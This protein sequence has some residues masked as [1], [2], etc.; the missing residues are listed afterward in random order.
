MS[1]QFLRG[2]TAQVEAYTG[3]AGEIVIN[4]ETNDIYIHDGTTQGG[5]KISTLQNLDGTLDAATLGGVAA[6]S[7]L[8]HG[9]NN[10]VGDEVRLTS[11]G[12]AD[13]MKLSLVGSRTYETAEVGRISFYNDTSGSPVEVAYISVDGT[14]KFTFSGDITIE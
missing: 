12:L 8:K 5:H 3:K 10:V 14:G 1:V 13:A 11:D 6:S 7:Y 4:T 9:D 2:T